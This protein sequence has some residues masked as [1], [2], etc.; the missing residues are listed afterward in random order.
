M[1]TTMYAVGLDYS[2]TPT[3]E[4]RTA[5]MNF[6]ES[7]AILMPCVDCRTGYRESLV[8][9]PLSV[10]STERPRLCNWLVTIQNATNSKLQKPEVTLDT[11]VST[12]LSGDNRQTTEMKRY[13]WMSIYCIVVDYAD[14]PTA[15]E[16]AAIK[17]FFQSLYT[18]MP[19]SAC[20]V[21]YQA[22][23]DKYP[24]D[25]SISSKTELWKW[26]V[27]VNNDING[28]VNKPAVTME[29]I[30]SALNSAKPTPNTISVQMNARQQIKNR[31][32]P[33][34]HKRCCGR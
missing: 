5:V 10:Y 14:T 23:L 9:Y 32:I 2:D 25:N 17:Q 30:I 4:Q 18:V 21:M 31:H 12:K 33:V 11:I 19:G 34:A 8:T 7:L 22:A 13:M 16:Q 15:E 1:W 6:Y 27:L 29:S 20:K 26:L 3:A 24:I 28:R